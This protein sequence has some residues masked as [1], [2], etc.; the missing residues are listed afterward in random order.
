VRKIDAVTLKATNIM[1]GSTQCSL[2]VGVYDC[3]KYAKSAGDLQGSGSGIGECMLLSLDI[4]R[5]LEGKEHACMHALC[6]YV[7]YRDKLGCA[8]FQYDLTTIVYLLLLMS[9]KFSK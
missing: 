8:N 2:L 4:I 3:V 9:D 6:R 7:P 1:D 5:I